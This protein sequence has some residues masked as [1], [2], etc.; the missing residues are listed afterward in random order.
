MRVYKYL[1]GDDSPIQIPES[2]AARHV[3]PVGSD[4]ITSLT[5]TL[6]L[7]IYMYILNE[8]RESYAS[9]NRPASLRHLTVAVRGKRARKASQ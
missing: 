9:R 6:V 1:Q 3:G 7:F 2:V 8:E 5:N 4:H